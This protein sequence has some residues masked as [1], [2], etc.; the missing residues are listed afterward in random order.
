MSSSNAARPIWNALIR[1]HHIT[2][3]KKVAKLRQAAAHEDVFALLRSGS[4]PGVMYCEGAM[5]NVENWVAAVQ[6]LRYKDFQLVARPAAIERDAM[7]PSGSDHRTGLYETDS[8]KD[9]AVQ[10]DNRGILAWW[11]KGMG[12]TGS[13]D[14]L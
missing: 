7:H 14:R 3:R 10:M 11:K 4:P 2:S 6:R 8:V 9:F 13:E 5:G 1:T 12:Y